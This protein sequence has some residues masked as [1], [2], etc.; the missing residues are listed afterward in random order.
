[1]HWLDDPVF[2]SRLQF[3][4]TIMFHILWPTL[5]I[6]LS[7]FL[8]LMEA[9]W[10]KTGR[11]RYYRHCRFWGTIFL[12]N[13]AIGVSS[14]VPM[15]FQ[16]G[17]NWATF[18]AATGDFFGNILGF[19]AAMAFAMEA[20][21]LAIMMFGWRR[22]SP[23]V[24]LLSTVLVAAGASLSAFWIMDANSWMQTPA[25]VEMRAGHLVPV[26]YLDAI[27][28]EDVALA[29]SHM[30][31]ACLEISLFVIAGLSAWRILKEKNISFF[32][33]SFKVAAAAAI[34]VAPLQIYLGDASGRLIARTQPAKVAAMESHWDTNP[35]GRGAPWALVALPDN[36]KEENRWAIRIPYLLSILTTHTMTG[37]VKGLRNFPPGDRPPILLPFYAFRIMVGLG[38]A[39]FF[40]MIWTVWAWARGLLS[41]GS[42]PSQKR[43]LLF[44]LLG[45]PAPYIAM[46]M[47]W[48]VREVGRQP[49]VVYG[50]LR[51]ER[52]ASRLGAGSLHLSLL[53]YCVIY[54]IL[55]ILFLIFLRRIMLKG[56]D[57]ESPLPGRGDRGT[58]TGTRRDRKHTLGN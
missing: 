58:A 57:L 56:P 47:G 22:V 7:L 5:T 31:V 44:W 37:T 4:F 3:S 54:A 55:L 46:E 6:G 20:A 48:I 23:G 49:W 25:G 1:M 45:I 2:L 27:F 14:G 13:F 51:T 18:A 36:V 8:V 34:V 17:T 33:T 28:N 26:N 9:L 41:E 29:F 19:E 38:F 43:L 21:F 50:I 39:M 35:P 10:L 15:E 42:A 53:A 12:L 16:F 24:H 52:A 40:L 11:E 32:L 30:W